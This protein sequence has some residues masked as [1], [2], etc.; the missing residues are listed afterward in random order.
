MRAP[1]PIYDYWVEY[2]GWNHAV[3]VDAKA[4]NGPT[5][6]VPV[7]DAVRALN[8]ILAAAP[9]LHRPFRQQ[10]VRGREADRAEG[11]PVDHVAPDVCTGA[12]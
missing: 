7:H 12:L 11:N 2:R 8:V 10:P 9:R 1:K 3:G 5:T 6:G 4:Q